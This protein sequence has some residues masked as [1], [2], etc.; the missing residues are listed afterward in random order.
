MEST[1]VSAPFVVTRKTALGVSTIKAASEPGDREV[2]GE[3]AVVRAAEETSV[4]RTR[5]VEIRKTEP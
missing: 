5:L 2:L 1:V 4:V 3:V